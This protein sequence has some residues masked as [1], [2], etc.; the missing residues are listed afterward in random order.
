MIDFKFIF[1]FGTIFNSI[2]EHI[3][4]I[5]EMYLVISIH[6]LRYKDR[7]EG[8]EK[9]KDFFESLKKEILVINKNV[10]LFN[11]MIKFGLNKF[12]NIEKLKP[13]PLPLI[14]KI[15]YDHKGDLS[16]KTNDFKGHIASLFAEDDSASSLSRKNTILKLQRVLLITKQSISNFAKNLYKIEEPYGKILENKV[17]RSGIKNEIKKSISCY[18]IGLI[19]E[20]TLIIGRIL[21][22]LTKDYLIKLKK[23]K[24][25]DYK[26]TVIKDAD[27]DT[28]INL[29]KKA[30]AISPSQ[31]SKITTIKWDRN[32]FSHPSKQV[33]IKLSIKDAKAVISLGCSLIEFFEK[34]L[35]L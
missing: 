19:G 8:D 2:A 20:A 1:I 10:S 22:K 26:L 30:G 5:E 21:E 29:L 7:K 24:K 33:D 4:K 31:F 3:K 15:I 18:S 12:T 28:K 25:I 14:K 6:T 27:F 35:S 11:E 13:I 34:K 9:K 16:D 17:I 23:A 32:I